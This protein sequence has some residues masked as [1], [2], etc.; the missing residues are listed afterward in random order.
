MVSGISLI[1]T[2]MVFLLGRKK[3]GLL[4]DLGFRGLAMGVGVDTRIAYDT[5]TDGSRL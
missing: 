5:T 3:A 4:L 1:G 2:M